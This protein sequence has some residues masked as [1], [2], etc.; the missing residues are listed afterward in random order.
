MTEPAVKESMVNAGGVR[1]PAKRRLRG[2]KSI[3]GS[4][5]NLANGL[6]VLRIVLVP[7]F[8]VLMVASQMT[9]PGYRVA[10]AL[11][12]VV[13]SLT[14]F[15]DGWIARTFNQVTSFGK[16]ADPIADKA[17][18]G[19]ALVMLSAYGALPWWITAVIVV[20]E[21]GVTLLRFW[22]IRFGVISAS[23]GGKAKT[24][25]QILAITWYI[26]PFSKTLAAVGPWI[27]LVAVVVTVV[28]GVDYVLRA[29]RNSSRVAP[30]D[31]LGPG[32]S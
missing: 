28:T 20:R 29:R 14:D 18:T 7:I 30:S 15:A 1:P 6:T 9:E 3:G 2:G 10:A 13:A 11:T 25:L 32:N 22:V 24:V 19:T 31:G 4:N 17:L 23:R 21:I 5:L 27:M 26:L 8:V 12:F 16:L